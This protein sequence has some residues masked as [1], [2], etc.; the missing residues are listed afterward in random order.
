MKDIANLD[1][2]KVDKYEYKKS[3]ICDFSN[4]PRPH[5]CM[6]FILD[7]SADF[8]FFEKEKKETVHVEPGDIIFV[9]ITSEYISY[10]NGNPDISYISFHFCF[11]EGC[12]IS[13]K[14]NFRIQKISSSETKRLKE[15][16]VTAYETYNSGQ[17]ENLVTL[18]KFYSVLGEVLPKLSHSPEQKYDERIEKAVEYINL[19]S[20]SDISVPKLASMC[21]LSTSHFYS[22][23]KKETGLS[24]IDYKNKILVNRASKLLIT[25]KKHSIEEISLLLGFSSSTYFRRVFKNFTGKSPGEY[26]KSAIEV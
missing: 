3:H 26:K 13:E 15:S 8:I 5:F 23:F 17:A 2:F 14:N 9:P 20:E 4:C 12:G 10:W 6:G 11:S 16:Y 21:N 1:F 18:G 7:G 24:P 22:R 25:H 19:N